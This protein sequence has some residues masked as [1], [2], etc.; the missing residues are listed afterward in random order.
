LRQNPHW[1]NLIP[2]TPVHTLPS[3]FRLQV[4]NLQ[5]EK[6][7][8]KPNWNFIPQEKLALEGHESYIF[9]IEGPRL[10]EMWGGDMARH[11]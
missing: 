10:V 5:K 4:S 3:Q 7:K 2:C 9:V 1:P 8:T 11:L 6:L